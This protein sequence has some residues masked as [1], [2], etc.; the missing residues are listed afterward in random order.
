[1]GI[2]SLIGGVL[3]ILALL[4]LIRALLSWFMRVGGDP[5]TRLLVDVT[6]PILAPIRR[7]TMNLMPG[8]PMDFS[9]IIAM[10][11]LQFLADLIIRTLR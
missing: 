1:M 3:D 6:E 10:I 8:M 4:I 5:V 2:G 11:A 7:F 9:P